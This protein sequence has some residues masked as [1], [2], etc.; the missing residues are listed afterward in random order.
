MPA[1][2]SGSLDQPKAGILEGSAALSDIA[3]WEGKVGEHMKDVGGHVLHVQDLISQL[4]QAILAM[5]EPLQRALGG[6]RAV[7]DGVEQ[8]SNSLRKNL[9]QTTASKEA[10]DAAKSVDR[11]RGPTKEFHQHIGALVTWHADLNAT[12]GKLKDKADKKDVTGKAEALPEETKKVAGTLMQASAVLDKK[13][14]S[15]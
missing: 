8:Y 4:D 5:G 11:Q 14:K 7:A 1:Y 15:V 3:G 6:Q 12:V 2:E 10:L 13:G 9:G